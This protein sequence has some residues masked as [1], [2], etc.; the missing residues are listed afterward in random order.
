MVVPMFAQ[1]GDPNDEWRYYAGDN[2]NSKY[3]PAYFRRNRRHTHD[4]HG[5]R[6]AIYRGHGADRPPSFTALE[7]P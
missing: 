6:H 4:L 3:S 2:G 1:Y 7:L 5:R